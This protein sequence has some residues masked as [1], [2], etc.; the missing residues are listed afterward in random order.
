MSI[1]VNLDYNSRKL[2]IFMN[3]E[4]DVTY[5]RIAGFLLK[6]HATLWHIFP[7]Y[8]LAQAALGDSILKCKKMLVTHFA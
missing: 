5:L 3:K 6:V 4:T 8:H 2:I 1:G 7:F